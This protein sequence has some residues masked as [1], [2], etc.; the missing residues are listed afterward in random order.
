MA[1]VTA[2]DAAAPTRYNSINPMSKLAARL[3]LV[4]AL[5]G[6]GASVAAAYV[7]YRLLYDPRYLSFCDVNQTIS[8]TQVYLS[9]FSTVRGIPVALFGALWFVVAGLLSVSGMTARAS[10]RESVPGY[11]FVLST[12]RVIRP[13]EGR[14]PSVP[15][16]LCRGDRALCRVRRGHIISHDH[17]A[18][19]RRQRCPR[20]CRQPTGRRDRHS[21]LRR[22]GHNARVFSA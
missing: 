18:T 5:V 6:V 1:F 19:P 21:L 15:D 2:L 3:A 11:L 7:H 4:F 9:R 22:S 13:A 17:S 14:V 16:H 10:V 8:C 20:L 12:L